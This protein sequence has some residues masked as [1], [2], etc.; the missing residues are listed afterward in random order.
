MY[1]SY[2]KKGKVLFKLL[3]QSIKFRSGEELAEANTKTVTNH[4]DSNEFGVLTFS[5]KDVLDAGG[6][7]RR[8]CS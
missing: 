4:L 7:K 5:V 2:L 8:D 6:R 3:L 1:N